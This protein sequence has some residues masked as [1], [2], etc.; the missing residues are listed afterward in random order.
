[1]PT[2]RFRG[3]VQ[4]SRERW[5]LSALRRPAPFPLARIRTAAWTPKR[6]CVVVRRTL[7]PLLHPL[8]CPEIAAAS[9]KSR[10]DMGNSSSQGASRL[11]R[12]G[13]SGVRESSRTGIT[14]PGRDE[15]AARGG[16]GPSRSH[17]RRRNL[18][19]V[20]SRVESPRARRQNECR[21]CGRIPGAGAVITRLGARVIGGR[22][23]GEAARRCGAGE[24]RSAWNAPGD[25][26][27]TRRGTAARGT[28]VRHRTTTGLCPVLFATRTLRA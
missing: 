13:G 3:S 26:A 16:I 19:R 27:T 1:M 11:L 2:R 14:A 24:P 4:P 8:P 9:A 20:C 7:H 6:G 5:R 15:L 10:A 25:E 21:R 12:T 17:A 22:G 18:S 23:L 28:G